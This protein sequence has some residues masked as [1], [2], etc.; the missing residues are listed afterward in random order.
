[1]GSGRDGT[2]ATRGS[3][4]PWGGITC[5]IGS[6]GFKLGAAALWVAQPVINMT[7]VV[8]KM[9]SL[10]FMILFWVIKDRYLLQRFRCR[11]AG[12]QGLNAGEIWHRRHARRE[13]HRW[14]IGGRS[15]F[16]GRLD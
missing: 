1:M 3:W 2:S 9:S 14:G 8:A 10:W 4:V 6:A 13:L 11:G 15:R 12:W 5:T 16:G 7:P